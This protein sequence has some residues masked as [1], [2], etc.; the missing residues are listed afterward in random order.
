MTKDR[1][2]SILA[3]IKSNFKV[4]E[5]NSYFQER[6][7]GIDVE[8][9]VFE[10]PIGTMKLELLSKPLVIDKKVIYSNRIGSDAKVEYK[11]SDNEKSL[12]MKAYKWDEAHIDWIEIEAG[13][14]AA[15]S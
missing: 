12:K 2:D 4:V 13:N 15:L 5:E 11:Y 14:L 6:D 9:I 3:N 8:M 10:G 7:G 1:W